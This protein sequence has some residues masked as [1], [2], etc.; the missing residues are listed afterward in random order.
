M[1]ALPLRKDVPVSE[2]WDLSLLFATE[3]AF[4]KELRQL[5]T[6]V[7]AFVKEY[8]GTL[9]SRER[10]CLSLP[11]Y[12]D[13][14][15][16]MYRASTYASLFLSAEIT[17]TVNQERSGK[18]GLLLNKLDTELAFYMGEINRLSAEELEKLAEEDEAHRAFWHQTALWRPHRLSEE[19]E[20]LLVALN[21]FFALPEEAY[22]A[23]KL[24]DLK[25]SPFEVEGKTY[26]LDFVTFENTYQ[27]EPDTKVRR[28]AFD[29]FSNDLR[30]MGNIFATLYNGQVQ[31]E[32]TLATQRGFDSVID[33]LLFP[34]QVSR[35][36]Y[37]RQID[38]IMKELA[39]VMRRYAKLLQRVHGWDR[40]TYADL[41]TPLDPE[42]T[43]TVTRKEAED[44]TREAL[45]VLGPEYLAVVEDALEHR[46][47]DYASNQGK[48][49]GGFCASPYGANSYILLSWNA[50]LSEVFTLV[51]ELGHAVHFHESMKHQPILQHEVSL[52]MVE[53]PS[54]CNEMLL[55]RYLLKKSDE[56]R[57]RRWVLS[58]MVANTYYHN[59]VTHLLEAD[60]QRKVYELVDQGESLHFE[61]LCE[62]KRETLAAFWGDEVELTPGC[63]L[64]WMR[65]PHYYGGLYSYTYSAGLTL[66]TVASKRI[67][68][69]GERGVEA[70]LS[71]LR[72]GGSE[73]PV[74]LAK[75]VGVDLHRE[76]ALRETIAY[77][78]EAVTEMEKLTE[79]LKNS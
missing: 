35:E 34:Q 38:V 21:D 36:L 14:I 1:S 79:E 33:F 30:G 47:I 12:E 44:Y 67:Y 6:D 40:I 11:V 24:A 64:T 56:P 4:E 42:M 62:L 2:T 45:R 16:R 53:A 28:A 58:S 39:P 77:I 71:V 8:T 76:D 48:S 78:D 59:F 49:T 23:G 52:Y 13:L 26:P 37:D 29:A 50:L 22:N 17:S 25:F 19:S 54:T 66:A 46:W 7:A 73:T 3:E 51:H 60:Y 69:E 9:T 55:S 27:Y 10:I 74:E 5:E 72:A 68:E 31:R 65:Q 41:K 70:W 18:S 43:P 57:F 20:K 32:K 63:E 15:A 75:R 61:R